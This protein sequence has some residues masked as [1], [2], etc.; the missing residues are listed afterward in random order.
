MARHEFEGTNEIVNGGDGTNENE[1]V[2]DGKE[3]KDENDVCKMSFKVLS[4]YM[5]FVE[6]ADEVVGK[7]RRILHLFKT[8]EE[9]QLDTKLLSCPYLALCLS[10]LQ[11]TYHQ[12]LPLQYMYLP[13]NSPPLPGKHHSHIGL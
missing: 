11:K 3:I 5:P 1:A 4:K 10:Y 9:A 13:L 12:F 8:N 6:E 7:N 2:G